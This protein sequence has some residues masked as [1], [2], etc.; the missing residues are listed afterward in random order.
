MY[1]SCLW[2]NWDWI[3]QPSFTFFFRSEKLSKLIFTI[4]SFQM[5]IPG[6]KIEKQI[7]LLSL[8]SILIFCGYKYRLNPNLTHYPQVISSILV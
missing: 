4:L 7:G 1:S 8:S 6:F 5:S 3:D 2:R